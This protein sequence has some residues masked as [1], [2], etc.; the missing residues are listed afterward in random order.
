MTSSAEARRLT[1]LEIW[2]TTPESPDDACEFRGYAGSRR[3]A[4]RY[5]P[6]Y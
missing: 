6:G 1:H 2:G 5:L 3:I 4:T